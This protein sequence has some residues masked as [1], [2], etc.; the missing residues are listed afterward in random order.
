MCG[1]ILIY[2]REKLNMYE[3]GFETMENF[4]ESAHKKW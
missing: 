4:Q 3:T 2:G 1:L